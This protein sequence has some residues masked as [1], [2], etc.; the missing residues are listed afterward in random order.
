METASVSFR[1][2]VYI[3]LPRFVER[4]GLFRFVERQTVHSAHNG[5]FWVVCVFGEKSTR[6]LEGCPL[7]ST[8]GLYGC[9]RF[10]WARV[11]CSGRG[12]RIA[13]VIPAGVPCMAVD[14]AKWA[15]VLLPRGVRSWWHVLLVIIISSEHNLLK[16]QTWQAYHT[17]TEKGPLGQTT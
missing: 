13:R 15:G 17:G 14:D 6:R 3:C 8:H 4:Y 1:G 12:E 7:F 5:P 11:P 9:T 16:S 10:A 2:T